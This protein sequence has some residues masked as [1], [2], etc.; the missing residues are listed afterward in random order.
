[1]VERSRCHVGRLAPKNANQQKKLSR[2]RDLFTRRPA[3]QHQRQAD[4]RLP[5]IM[6]QCTLGAFGPGLKKITD[7]LDNLYS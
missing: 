4:Q 1:M 7:K 5:P 3:G 2:I 6:D